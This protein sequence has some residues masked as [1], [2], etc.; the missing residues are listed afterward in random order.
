MSV[1]GHLSRSILSMNSLTI[2]NTLFIVFG[3]IDDV[4]YFIII[5]DIS[6]IYWAIINLV[7]ITFFLIC[8]CQLSR[9]YT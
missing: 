4:W 5:S 2:Q 1:G 3:I 7:K 6:E 8:N 9:E